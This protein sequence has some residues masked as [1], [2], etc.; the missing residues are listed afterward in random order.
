ME[1]FYDSFPT[2]QMSD[3]TS[4]VLW[5]PKN[6][7]YGSYDGVC[8]GIFRHDDWF[9]VLGSNFLRN[10]IATFDISNAQ[11]SFIDTE[12]CDYESY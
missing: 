7:M 8:I 3:G 12:N 10:K 2:I 1:E 11:V 6:Y 5:Q 4:K 9:N